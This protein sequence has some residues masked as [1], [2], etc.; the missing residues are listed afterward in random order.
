MVA[1]VVA[2]AAAVVVAAATAAAIV[3][4]FLAKILKMQ[5]IGCDVITSEHRPT[6]V[7]EVP[8]NYPHFMEPTRSLQC[9]KCPRKQ[10]V[11]RLGRSKI[12]VTV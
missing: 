4:N 3:L 1:V 9:R 7:Q 10:P 5:Q 2:V 6:I 8:N 11:L 12:S